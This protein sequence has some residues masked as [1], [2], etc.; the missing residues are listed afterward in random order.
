MSEWEA[1]LLKRIVKE[2]EGVGLVVRM[3]DAV[4]LRT[5][6]TVGGFLFLF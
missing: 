5:T 3:L 6:F 4:M 1:G 2:V